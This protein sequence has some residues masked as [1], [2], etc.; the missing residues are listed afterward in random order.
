MFDILGK[1]GEMKA[2]LEE[3]QKAIID[4]TVTAE[5]GAGLVKVTMNG[6][7]Q[8]QKIEIDP[9]LLLESETEMLQ[10]LLV[11]AFNLAST[12]AEEQAAA[13]MQSK[14]AGMLPSIPGLDLS[15]FGK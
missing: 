15:R 10:D 4:V 13:I 1:M 6:N 8:A 3:A 11:A 5:A 14:T 2:R 9:S 12:R 7:R